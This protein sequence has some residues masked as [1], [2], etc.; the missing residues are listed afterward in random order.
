MFN[1]DPKFEKAN[2]QALTAF[3]DAANDVTVKL[4][5]KK[6]AATAEKAA[7]S[8]AERAFH[9]VKKPL[10]NQFGQKSSLKPTA[11]N[12]SEA[13]GAV[14]RARE[15]GADVTPALRALTLAA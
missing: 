13:F 2:G 12:M 1:R 6:A 3:G 14:R 5:Q 9:K 4:E 11:A 8:L 7:R 15:V 10:T